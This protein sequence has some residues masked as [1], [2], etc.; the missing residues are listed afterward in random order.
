MKTRAIMKTR[1]RASFSDLRK[2]FSAWSKP[3]TIRVDE[4][5]KPGVRRENRSTRAADEWSEHDDL[6]DLLA[7]GGDGRKVA[8][9]S[10]SVHFGP[11]S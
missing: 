6:F 1:T 8:R 3:G 10:S 4:K 9:L 5:M 7:Q 11:Y 2:T